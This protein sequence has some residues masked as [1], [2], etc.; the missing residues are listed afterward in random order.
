MVLML[1]FPVLLLKCCELALLQV[2]QLER[3]WFFTFW[4]SAD[5][6]RSQT[7]TT[8]HHH[9][10]FMKKHQTLKNVLEYTSDGRL[11]KSQSMLAPQ[12]SG[13]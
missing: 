9:A 2:T 3:D 6:D 12:L 7:D 13:Q 4:G 10:L 11:V 5:M 1:D 8:M